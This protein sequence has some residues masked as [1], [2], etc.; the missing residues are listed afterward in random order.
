MEGEKGGR[1]GGRGREKE[2]LG[3]DTAPKTCVSV[4][5]ILQLGPTSNG[6]R[7][8]LQH[9][10]LAEVGKHFMFNHFLKKMDRTMKIP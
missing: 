6:W 10:S 2:W 1:V 7:P 3:K 9:M 4:T 8:R 5:Y